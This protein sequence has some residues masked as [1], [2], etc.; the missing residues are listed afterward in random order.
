MPLTF[1]LFLA[2]LLLSLSPS[3]A[4]VTP[5]SPIRVPPLRLAQELDDRRRIQHLLALTQPVEQARA[6]ARARRRRAPPPSGTRP[7]PQ[8]NSLLSP[9]TVRPQEITYL[10]NHKPD[11][12]VYYPRSGQAGAQQ[13]QQQPSPSP[14]AAFTSPSAPAGP[15][16]QAGGGGGGRARVM[17]TVYMPTANTDALLLKVES[18]QAQLDE[19]KQFA[20]ERTAALLEDRRVSIYSV[21][22]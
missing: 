18:L 2:L 7:L 12:M 21:D 13:Q 19:A 10:R 22:G 14:L 9:P 8:L 1:P 15:S 20:A 11:A 6:S 16:G 5:A 17:R 3:S 4:S